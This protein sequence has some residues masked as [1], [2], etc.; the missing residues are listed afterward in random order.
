MLHLISENEVSDTSI[1]ESPVLRKEINFM[2][3]V[4][5]EATVDDYRNSITTYNELKSPLYFVNEGFGNLLGY[6]VKETP[7]FSA[8]R[9]SLVNLFLIKSVLLPRFL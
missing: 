2:V 6:E 7:Y 1:R 3:A 5:S 8:E 4:A 9:M